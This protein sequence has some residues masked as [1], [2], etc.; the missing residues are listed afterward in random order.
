MPARTCSANW[1]AQ[2]RFCGE[3]WLISVPST[4]VGSSSSTD[5]AARTKAGWRKARSADA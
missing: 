4:S 1:L 2:V 3:L 5:A